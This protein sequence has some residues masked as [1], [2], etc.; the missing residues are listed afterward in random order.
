M[1]HVLWIILL[2]TSWLFA[3]NNAFS[4]EQDKSQDHK[5]YNIFLDCA[6]QD[7]HFDCYNI[8]EALKLKLVNGDKGKL[9]FLVL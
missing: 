4:Q 9:L 8:R 2:C 5:N 3:L 7:D 1:K 6:T